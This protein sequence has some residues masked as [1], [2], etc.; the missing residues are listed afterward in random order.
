[1]DMAFSTVA[2]TSINLK[3]LNPTVYD[4]GFSTQH[5]WFKKDG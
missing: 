5:E 1:M 3:V 2:L 4:E